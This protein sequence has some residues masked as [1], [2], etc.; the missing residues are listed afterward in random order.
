MLSH[1][2]NN[3][4]HVPLMCVVDYKYVVVLLKQWT[5]INTFLYRGYR[6]LVMTAVPIKSKPV[7]TTVFRVS[8]LDF[9]FNWFIIL[10]FD[11]FY[12]RMKHN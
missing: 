12:C 3:G 7:N 10:C 8:N 11:K 1:V 9:P 6:A 5:V 4:V 2:K